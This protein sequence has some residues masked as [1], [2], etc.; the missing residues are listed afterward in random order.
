VLDREISLGKSSA[1]CNKL[2]ILFSNGR[3]YEV[4]PKIDAAFLLNVGISRGSENHYLGHHAEHSG[5]LKA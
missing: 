4:L 5:G 2:L 1:L 3:D